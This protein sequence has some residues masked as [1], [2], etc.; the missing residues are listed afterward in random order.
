MEESVD[1][2]EYLDIL[3]FPAFIVDCNSYTPHIDTVVPSPES[4]K[5]V[6][7]N[8]ACREGSLGNHVAREIKTNA[9]FRKWLSFTQPDGTSIRG[10]E[11]FE[12]SHLEFSFNFLRSNTFLR[13]G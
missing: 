12:T 8:K 3:P 2:Q 1:L 5:R 4:I 9:S 7:A 13:G 6:F 11:F 10:Q